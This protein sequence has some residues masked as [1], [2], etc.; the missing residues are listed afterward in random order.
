LE[1]FLNLSSVQRGIQEGKIDFMSMSRR[2]LTDPRIKHLIPKKLSSFIAISRAG[3]LSNENEKYDGKKIINKKTGKLFCSAAPQ[4]NHNVLLP[5]GDVVL[6]CMDY[7]IDHKIGNLLNHSYEELFKS[8]KL[9]EIFEILA[10]DTSDKKLLC[11]TCEYAK[12]AK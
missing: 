4:L 7:S 11:R 12:V 2:G 5:N 9:K 8:E 10:D 6:C 3:N 1:Y